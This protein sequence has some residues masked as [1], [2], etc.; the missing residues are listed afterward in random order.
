M[1]RLA[2]DSTASDFSFFSHAPVSGFPE[3]T[4]DGKWLVN[5]GRGMI[6]AGRVIL[7]TNAYTRNFFPKDS[8][9]HTHISPYRAYCAVVTPT[10]GAS[11]V[12][13]LKYTYNLT[14][15]TYM[16]QTGAGGIV[17]GGGAPALIR[18]GKVSA[19]ELFGQIDDS[20]VNEACAQCKYWRRRDWSR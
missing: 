5:T 15:E 8:L 12:N 1:M 20:G 16:V 11:G 18:E 2:I 17:L 19:N 14:D 10:P 6:K 13:A 9:L 4:D 7:C 3:R